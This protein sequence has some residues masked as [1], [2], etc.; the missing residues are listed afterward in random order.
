MDLAGEP[1]PVPKARLRAV[2]DRLLEAYDGKT[3]KTVTRDV[4]ELVAMGLLVRSGGGYRANLRALDSFVP[5]RRP[6][7]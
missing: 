4:N 7:E 1:A 5:P 6:P 2:S 3:L